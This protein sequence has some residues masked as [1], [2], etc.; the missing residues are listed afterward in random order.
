MKP[1]WNNISSVSELENFYTDSKEEFKLFFKHSTRCSVS[2]MALRF[3]ESEIE[4]KENACYYFI[5]L[6]SYREVSNRLAELS[7]VQHQSPQVILL[8]NDQVIYQASHHSIDA[9]QI[10]KLIQND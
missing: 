8:K 6:I 9:N 5:D 1:F 3:F 7:G 2:S 10:N 4:I